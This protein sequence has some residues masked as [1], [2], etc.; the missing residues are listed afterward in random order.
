MDYYIVS[1]FLDQYYQ[2]LQDLRPDS[3]AGDYDIGFEVAKRI[4]ISPNSN[5]WPP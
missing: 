4:E 3:T 1:S 2:L 5:G